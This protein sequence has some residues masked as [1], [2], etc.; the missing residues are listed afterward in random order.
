MRSMFTYKCA[1]RLS[2][3]SD[4]QTAVNDALQKDFLGNRAYPF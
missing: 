3:G 4:I 2:K 1:E